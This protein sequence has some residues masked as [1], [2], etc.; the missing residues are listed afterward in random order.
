MDN[1]N[2]DT[3]QGTLIEQLNEIIRKTPVSIKIIGFTVLMYLVH[4][5]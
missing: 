3:E 1:N 5:S 2:N 4:W